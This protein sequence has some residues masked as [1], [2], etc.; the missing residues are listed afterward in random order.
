MNPLW[1]ALF[2]QE[3]I[4]RLA[5]L[6]AVIVIGSIILYNVRRSKTAS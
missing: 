1:A 4:S 6:G 5:L 3:R 2:A